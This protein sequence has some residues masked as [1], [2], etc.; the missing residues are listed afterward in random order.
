MRQWK[1]MRWEMS[2]SIP[3]HLLLGILRESACQ[4]AEQ[5]TAAGLT[6]EDRARWSWRINHRVPIMAPCFHSGPLF[7]GRIC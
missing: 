3:D 7:R 2:G 5:L 4:A 6:F 1:L